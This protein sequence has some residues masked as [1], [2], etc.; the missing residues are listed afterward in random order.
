MERWAAG[1]LGHGLQTYGTL[2]LDFLGHLLHAYRSER[3]AQLRESRLRETRPEMEAGDPPPDD[4][5]HRLVTGYMTEHGQL[6]PIADWQACWRHLRATGA[7]PTLS[8]DQL[9]EYSDRSQQ[10]LQQE[11]R[12]ARL[13]GKRPPDPVPTTGE[14]WHAYLRQRRAQ[15]YYRNLLTFAS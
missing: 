2:S 3:T 4:F 14:L 12:A 1:E 13:A 9:Q 15:E 6:P 10:E 11:T 7:L 5:H 8:P